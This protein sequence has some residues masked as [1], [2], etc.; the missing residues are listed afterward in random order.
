MEVLNDLHS[1]LWYKLISAWDE[2]IDVPKVPA[3][4]PHYDIPGIQS[5]NEVCWH[6]EVEI[7]AIAAGLATF[8]YRG[9]ISCAFTAPR[10]A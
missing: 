7:G 3:F 10:H 9:I 4:K 8:F 6:R 2:A 1:I 5:Y